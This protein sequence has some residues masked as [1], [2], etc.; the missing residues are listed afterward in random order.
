MHFAQNDVKKLAQ[1]A[2][3]YNILEV[4][5]D[6][7]KFAQTEEAVDGLANTSSTAVRF[8]WLRSF[9]LVKIFSDNCSLCS[10]KLLTT[11]LR[12]HF[13]EQNSGRQF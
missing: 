11:K 7:L 1:T 8:K 9:C 3:R 2:K 5:G 13:A 12:L 10:L 6:H 4:I